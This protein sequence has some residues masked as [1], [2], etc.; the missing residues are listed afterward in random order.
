MTT[1]S[2]DRWAFNVHFMLA[3]G[4]HISPDA[5]VS[6]YTYQW[7]TR[8]LANGTYI[9]YAHAL[10]TA[11]NQTMTPI[12]ITINN[13][14]NNPTNLLTNWNLETANGL[15]PAWWLQ[16]GYGSN[17]RSFTY[18]S[19]GA[20]SGQRSVKVDITTYTDGDAKWYFTDVP[21]TA[22]TTYTYSQ[23]YTSTVPTNLFA[24]YLLPNN[25]YQYQ[26]I[27]AIPTN[28]T[29]TP[30]TLTAAITPPSGTISMT[31]W[32]A[33]S[34]IGSLT[35]DDISLTPPNSGTG[36]TPD[37]TP[38]VVSITNPG[39][40]WVYS[41]S[42]SFSATAT[43]NIGVSWVDFL[44]DGVVINTDTTAPYTTTINTLTYTGWVHILSVRA[45]DAAN[46]ITTSSPRN[47]FIN[48]K[49]P[50]G[51]TTIFS[52][53]FESG[54]FSTGWTLP[55]AN[56]TVTAGTCRSGTDNNTRATRITGTIVPN[57][58]GVERAISLASYTGVTLSF[59]Y[60]W[61]SLEGTDAV[62]IEYSTNNGA[63]W[64]IAKSI[65]NSGTI[66]MFYT[67]DNSHIAIPSSGSIIPTPVNIS[68]DN[69]ARYYIEL[70][71]SVSGNPNFKLRIKDRLSDANDYVWIDD[72]RLM[73]TVINTQ[74]TT[75]P[76]VTLTSPLSGS[77]LS[78]LINI[79]ATATDNIGVTWVQFQL[80]GVNIGSEDT[81]SPYQISYNTNLTSNGSHTFRAI[82]RDAA[83]NTRT[84]SGV[85][86]QVQNSTTGTGVELITNGGLELWTT[87]PTG[88]YTWGYGT[89]NRTF[90]YIS[91]GALT[92]QKSVK[93]DITT[94]TS[95]DGKWIFNE[96]PVSVGTTYTYSQK[97]ASTVPSSLLVRYTM[98]DNSYQYV[99]LKYLPTATTAVTTT[100]EFTVPLNVL[101]ATVWMSL[102]TIG[103]TIIDDVS[104]K[105]K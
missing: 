102:D 4:T 24:R 82:A 81:T 13:Q 20:L 50:P 103:S 87:A 35:L 48:N 85:T 9:V 86:V 26:Y 57:G 84:S 5:T 97:Y 29:T 55:N 63:S 91:T 39:A 41:G 100:T 36:T 68:A 59:C 67:A 104:L 14:T 19:T 28:N 1:V 16:G 38:P 15:L 25:I 7:D 96:V 99:Y 90:S 78:G 88:W 23:K 6:P 21:V 65:T 92:W 31:V 80:D 58:N 105:Q 45:R 37:T 93:V 72:I 22:G 71:A 12:T 52:E 27:R 79:T 42:I 64:T 56:Y 43:D 61:D 44:L 51:S 46:N 47:I 73:G 54:S 95:G 76:T 98:T 69:L 34:S 94:Y 101:R 49:T 8:T 60:K 2:D 30:L 3:N 32:D 83:W 11:G 70:P 10:D 75:L 66:H 89:N 33:L 62:D 18:L 53:T 17:N 74:D 77:T 40:E